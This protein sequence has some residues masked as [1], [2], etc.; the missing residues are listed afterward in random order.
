MTQFSKEMQTM[1]FNRKQLVENINN[2]IQQKKLKVG[3][4]EQAI[5]ISTG[6]ISRLSKAGNESIPA[7]DVIWKLARHFGVS[8]DALISGDFSEGTDNLSIL[9]K[10][11]KTLNVQTAEGLLKWS[12]VTTKY[13][14]GVLK[15]Q[16][17]LFF[18]VRET[19]EDCGVP[20]MREDF[21]EAN[22]T[23][24]RYKKRAINCPATNGD[25][26]WMIGDGFK[27]T[28]PDGKRV[29][30]FYMGAELDVG[31]PQIGTIDEEFYVMYL[32]EWVADAAEG[33]WKAAEVFSTLGPGYEL[34]DD[35]WDLAANLAMSA[36]DLEIDAGVKDAILSFLKNDSMEKKEVEEK[37]GA[38]G[39]RGG[40]SVD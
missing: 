32:E 23:Y 36:Y 5:G 7:T 3:E 10:F 18:L 38:A 13:V 11:V 30:L 25:P 40:I 31:V 6:Y 17:P 1:E 29:Y 37:A 21:S 16:E 19:G 33:H 15:G 4:V 39:N 22:R 35:V 27:T 14:N 2:I 20:Q 12:P 28:L 9:R 24:S 34:H 8:I 26:A